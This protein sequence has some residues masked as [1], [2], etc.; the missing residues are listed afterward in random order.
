MLYLNQLKY[1]DVPY[2]HNVGA[3]GVPP[4]R[5]TVAV[6]GCGL[7]CACMLVENM[8]F[9]HLGLTEC[10][11]LS[12]QAKAN[13]EPGTDMRLLGP[14]VAE[15]FGLTY[16]TTSD[17]EVLKEHLRRGGMAIANSG[18]DR[19]GYTGVFTRNGHYVLVVSVDGDEVCILDPSYKEGKYDEPG[20]QGKVRV[21]GGFEYCHVDVLAGDCSN[22]DPSYYLFARKREGK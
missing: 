19:E 10:R 5:A 4:E 22:R 20:R 17:V 7:C 11:D 16:E 9:S 15:K 3:G 13:M 21:E 12:Y 2:E 18:G 8:T 1:L 14:L 6:A